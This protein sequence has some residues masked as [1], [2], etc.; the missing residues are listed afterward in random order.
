MGL[1]FLMQTAY[2]LPLM[3]VSLVLAVVAL[4]YRA[5]RR[6]GFGPLAIGLVASVAIIAGKFVMDSNIVVYGSLAALIGASVWNSWPSRP[7]HE[8]YQLGSEANDD[9]G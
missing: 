1:G 5:K 8:L 7:T 4:G 3:V 2:L 6:W 9:S